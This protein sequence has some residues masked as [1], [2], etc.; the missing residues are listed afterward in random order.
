MEEAGA[1]PAFAGVHRTGL[2]I[3]RFTGPLKDVASGGRHR[4]W[5]NELRAETNRSRGRGLLNHYPRGARLLE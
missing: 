4:P 1:G 5:S 3:G 2:D